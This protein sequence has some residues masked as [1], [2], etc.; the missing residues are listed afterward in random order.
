MEEHEKGYESTRVE[1]EMGSNQWRNNPKFP[2]SPNLHLF[3]IFLNKDPN[4]QSLNVEGGWWGSR[5]SLVLREWGLS[6]SQEECK[7]LH[8]HMNSNL[9]DI[10]TITF[11]VHSLHAIQNDHSSILYSSLQGFAH[12]FRSYVEHCNRNM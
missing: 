5:P 3:T 7:R 9:M 10:Q 2:K 8:L 1:E 11:L 6:T 4:H 12:V